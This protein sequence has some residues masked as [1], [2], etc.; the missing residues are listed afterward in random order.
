MVHAVFCDFADGEVARTSRWVW[1]KTTPQ[2]AVAVRERGSTTALRHTVGE[3]A[4]SA[5]LMRVADL[6][7]R[8]AV[9]APPE[10]RTLY[11]GLRAS[12]PI[13]DGHTAQA[14]PTDADEFGLGLAEWARGSPCSRSE[15][16]N[17]GIPLRTR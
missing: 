1:G 6:A 3:L 17:G 13:P 10:G 16:V 4:D 2:E 5:N 7:T 8:A 15:N 11:A 14:R 12:Y 9:S